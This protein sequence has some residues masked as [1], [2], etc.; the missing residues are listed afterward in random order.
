MQFAGKSASGKTD[1]WEV[2][3]VAGGARL[4]MVEWFARWRAYAF[5]PEPNTIFE[6]ECLRRIALFVEDRTKQHRLVT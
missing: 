6:Q 1:R 4:G 5:K 2:I 3:A